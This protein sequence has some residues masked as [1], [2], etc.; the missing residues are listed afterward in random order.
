M[1]TS[2]L[3]PGKLRQGAWSQATEPSQGKG[4]TAETPGSQPG[5]HSIP[6]ETHEGCFYPYDEATSNH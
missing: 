6:W 5:I 3:A 4:E 1:L 2:N